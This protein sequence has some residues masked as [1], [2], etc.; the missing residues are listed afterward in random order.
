MTYKLIIQARTN[1]GRLPGKMLKPFFN[2]KTIPEIIIDKLKEYF[3]E[4]DIILA[5]TINPDDDHLV[6]AARN[7]GIEIFRGDEDDVLHRFIHAAETNDANVIVRI[8]ADNP[9]LQVDSI[10]QLLLMFHEEPVDYLSYELYDH[11]PV[12]KSHLG[13][14]AEVT[15]LKTLKKVAQI[16][17]KKKYR[18]HVTNY[19]Y[20]HPEIFKIKL[21]PLDEALIYRNEIRL[22]IDTLD[23]FKLC[24][25]IYKEISPNFTIESL[26]NAIDLDT[27]RVERMKVQIT[28]NSK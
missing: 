25:E 21:L 27:S 15:T 12:I 8:C 3:S 7:K 13:L 26:L 9:F 14:F 19:I 18:E 24:Q 10:R 1:S 2:D 20:A 17:N 6:N 22:T 5:T 28:E 4:Q 11:T 16:T 23:D